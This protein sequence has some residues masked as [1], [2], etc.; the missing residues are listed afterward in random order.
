MSDFFVLK[1]SIK[2]VLLLIIIS[3]AAT[4]MILKL[5]YQQI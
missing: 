3:D 4:W 2:K 1:E 5:F